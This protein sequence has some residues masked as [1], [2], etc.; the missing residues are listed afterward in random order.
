MMAWSISIG[1]CIYKGFA[2]GRVQ[3]FGTGVCEGCAITFMDMFRFFVV[4]ISTSFVLHCMSRRDIRALGLL[5]SSGLGLR[6]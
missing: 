4:Q 2:G 6:F 1:L 3:A 5:Q